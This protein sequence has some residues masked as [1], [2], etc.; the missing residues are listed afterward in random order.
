MLSNLFHHCHVE[1]ALGLFAPGGGAPFQWNSYEWSEK[2]QKHS[3]IIEWRLRPDSMEG[4]V[5]KACP[6]MDS[7]TNI[8][9]I[10]VQVLRDSDDEEISPGSSRDT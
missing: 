7:G 2:V 6:F 3:D 5:L 9:S 10:L 4:I 8:S 1:H